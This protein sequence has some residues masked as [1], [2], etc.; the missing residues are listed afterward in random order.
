[1]KQILIPFFFSVD[2]PAIKRADV[3]V[4]MGQAGTEITKQAADIV[5]VNDNFTSIV[6]AVEEGR[7]VFD[8]ILKFIVYLL[9]CN[10]AEIFLMLICTIANIEVPLTVMMI[11]WANIIADI[12][13][14][15]A[16]G[17][18]PNEKDIMRR[19]PRD[20]KMG[21]ITRTT[22]LIIFTNSML[23]AALAIAAYTISLYVLKFPLE[24]ARS[25]V[26]IYTDDKFQL[27]HFKLII[28]LRHLLP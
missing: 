2:A 13:P 23:I 18:E 11:L 26:S 7:H 27:E 24:I 4:A 20:P 21:V 8:N 25:M 10:G 19:N 17:V 28:S 6:D 22:W 5:L 15:M 9:S 3:G 14:A 12:P 1:M 16:L